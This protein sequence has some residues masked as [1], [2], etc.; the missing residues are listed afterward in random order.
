MA[1]SQ[2]FRFIKQSLTVDPAA[3]TATFSLTFSQPP[4][5]VAV[6][7]SQLEAF[8]YE[9][10]TGSEDISKPIPPSSLDTIIRGGEIFET[11]NTI[12]VRD[13]TGDGGA[14]SGGFGPVRATLPFTLNG[15]TLIFTA[16][17]SDIGDS[18][19]K[20]RYRVFTTDM[21]AITAD[22]QGTTAAIPLP[23][24]LWTGAVLLTGLFAVLAASKLFASFR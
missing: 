12:P 24:G 22:T 9:I 20:F 19:G 11:S 5:F 3:R 2:D 6:G 15:S 10:D 13:A 4:S 8:Q 7:G 16:N 17:F 18:D 21:G 23:A 1:G 14:N